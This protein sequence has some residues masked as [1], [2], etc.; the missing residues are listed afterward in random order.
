MASTIQVHVKHNKNLY[1]D[2]SI[3]LSQPSQVFKAQLFTLTGVP[4]D[5]QKVIIKGKPLADDILMS[6]VKL[7]PNM[8]LML[9]G[10]SEAIPEA[11]AVETIFVEDLPEEEQLG[12]LMGNRFSAG[13]AN[14][15][16]TCY[17]NSTLQ[18]LRVVEPLRTLLESYGA[19]S[20]AP[21][22]DSSHRLTLATK[23]VMAE[24]TRKTSKPVSPYMFLNVLR[25][26]FPTF[27]QQQNGIYSQQDAEECW[28]QLL[29]T[30]RTR[31]GEPMVD[32]FGIDTKT[33]L[34][35]EGAPDEKEVYNTTNYVMKC[36]ITI[37]VNHLHE[38]L[39][40]ALKE[41][42]EKR[43]TTLGTDAMFTGTAKLTKL[44]KY[45]TVQM[46]RFNTKRNNDGEFV[47][48][49]I[50]RSVSFPMVLDVFD[51]CDAAYQEEM[52]DAR[53]SLREMEEVKAGLHGGEAAAAA[54]AAASGDAME[55]EKPTP[56]RV[57]GQYELV[58]VLTHKGRSSDAGHYVGWVREEEQQQ[59]DAAASAEQNA[60]KRSKKGDDG[61][62]G[63]VKFDDDTVSAVTSD[64]VLRLHGGGDW[65]MGYLFLYRA[66]L[67]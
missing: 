65:H 31:L 46:M 28:T 7:K 32:L 15:G 27:A 36:N 49:K 45:L 1:K 13:L 21:T 24:I 58:A 18:C 29:Y 23:N 40:L 8:T 20:E 56:S 25:E 9:M 17:M 42:R 39:K 11:P 64:E 47:K 30:L 54:A 60:A 41:D 50:L 43:S 34:V 12:A 22:P 19:D 55:V 53:D 14:L 38:G 10:S 61:V 63:W 3:N 67:G 2:I 59:K 48:Q 33:E 16:N 37:D 52:K 35:C 5:R 66:K 26:A 57:T 4:V 62:P 6:T 51:M 44:P